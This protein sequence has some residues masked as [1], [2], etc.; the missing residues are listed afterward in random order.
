MGEAAPIRTPVWTVGH[1]TYFYSQNNI[2]STIWFLL[3]VNI[4]FCTRA[5]TFIFNNYIQNLANYIL[6]CSTHFLVMTHSYKLS[7]VS[8]VKE[9]VNSD[10]SITF[11][12]PELHKVHVIVS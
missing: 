11:C 6:I 10:G 3:V 4:I 5:N 12:P 1:C 8:S 2:Y 9:N 7:A